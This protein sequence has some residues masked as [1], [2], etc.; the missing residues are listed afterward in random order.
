MPSEIVVRVKTDQLCVI[1]RY[2]NAF[3]NLVLIS[4]K[5]G[6]ITNKRV[7]AKVFT[8]RHFF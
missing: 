8:E 6:C 7:C 1:F 5:S 2:V 3:L 4:S